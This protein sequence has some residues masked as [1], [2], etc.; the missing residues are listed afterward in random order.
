MKKMN[1][2]IFPLTPAYGRD[3]KSKSEVLKDFEAG[4][5]FKTAF[6]QFTNIIDL[7]QIFKGQNLGVQFR[8]QK[9]RRSLTHNFI[10]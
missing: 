9:N 2:G 8:F 3:Y 1:L 10:F 5:D 4:K 7:A 6:G